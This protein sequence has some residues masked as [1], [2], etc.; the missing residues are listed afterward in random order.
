MRKKPRAHSRRGMYG[1][2]AYVPN[3]LFVLMIEAEV[4][5]VPAPNVPTS[6]VSPS[7]QGYPST[8]VPARANEVIPLS[9]SSPVQ[10]QV[11]PSSKALLLHPVHSAPQFPFTQPST[12]HSGPA[13]ITQSQAPHLSSQMPNYHSGPAIITQ[14]QA[15]RPSSQ[16]PSYHSGPAIITQSQAPRPSSQ[17]P[18]YHSGPA[19][20]TQSQAP[21]PSNYQPSPMVPP[22]SVYP[23]QGRSPPLPYPYQAPNLYYPVSANTYSVPSPLQQMPNQQ[24]PSFNQSVSSSHTLYSHSLPHSPP[25]YPPP[26]PSHTVSQPA[27]RKFN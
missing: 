5:S 26:N 9:L 4:T 21:R 15:P 11:P 1:K 20:I 23:I 2:L 12:V 7:A 27:K 13:I 17:M 16:M 24:S 19:I 22:H 25:Y 8:A 18:I 10:P 3:L 6:P 14:S